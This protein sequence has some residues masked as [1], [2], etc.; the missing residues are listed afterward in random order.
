MVPAAYHATGSGSDDRHESLMHAA[1]T[2]PCN[3]GAGVRV[4]A[5]LVEMRMDL[6]ADADAGAVAGAAAAHSPNSDAAAK[7]PHCKGRS[8]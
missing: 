8:L 3:P 6:I 4:W 7:Q 2:G 5:F 1:G